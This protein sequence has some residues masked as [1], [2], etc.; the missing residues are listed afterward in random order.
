MFFLYLK[1]RLKLRWSIKIIIG[2]VV[3]A[4]TAG[5]SILLG[6]N[7]KRHLNLERAQLTGAKIPK[8]NLREANLQFAGLN[9]ADLRSA[10]LRDAN[11]NDADLRGADLCSA[12]LRGAGLHDANL[13]DANLTE[14]DL[15]GA[16]LRGADSARPRCGGLNTPI[17]PSGR[18]RFMVISC[19][20][21]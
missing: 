21:P 8:V 3:L 4:G 12:V 17:R 2:I 16:D 9:K 11:L 19:G 15:L 13:R 5:L 10:D 1:P 6:L 7:Y 20:E 14:A 18:T